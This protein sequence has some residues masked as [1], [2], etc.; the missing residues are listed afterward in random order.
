MVFLAMSRSTS[1]LVVGRVLVGTGTAGIIH[2]IF[3]SRLLSEK[4]ISILVLSALQGL[5]IGPVVGGLVSGRASWRWYVHEPGI[6]A[7][8]ARADLTGNFRVFWVCPHAI[9]FTSSNI[10]FLN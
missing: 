4:F 3:F 8:I 7:V 1:Y 5:G 2:G 9:C 6:Q 10:S